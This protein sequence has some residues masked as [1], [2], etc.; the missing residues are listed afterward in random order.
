MSIKI[1]KT[2]DGS[3]TLVDSK[4]SEVYHSKFGAINESTHIFIQH[5]LN[6]MMDNKAIEILEIGLGT[7]LNVLLTFNNI[8]NRKIRYTSIEPYPLN[9]SI[10]QLLNYPD[11]LEF[12]NALEVFNKIHS[13]DWQQWEPLSR[14]FKLLKFQEKLQDIM[15][16]DATFQLVYFDA[17]SPE[18]QPELWTPEIFKKLFKSMKSGG[19]LLTYSAKGSVKRAMIAAGF[20]IEKLPGPKGKRE[21]IRAIKSGN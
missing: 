14:Q 21:M 1:L 2:E 6:E 13:C 11:L 17:F 4:L 10:I 8:L 7:G 16:P 15:L 9:A 3:H 18:I 19:L 12:S 5:G 20:T